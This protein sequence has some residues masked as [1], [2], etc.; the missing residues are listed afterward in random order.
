MYIGGK[1]DCSHMQILWLG[2]ACRGGRVYG[3]II[4]FAEEIA[5]IVKMPLERK[6]YAI[7]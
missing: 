7:S 6:S 3:L 5:T 4:L 2:I 1:K